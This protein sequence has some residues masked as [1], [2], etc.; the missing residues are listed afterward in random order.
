MR[1]SLLLSAVL[2]SAYILQPAAP[3][4]A[5]ANKQWD[6]AEDKQNVSIVYLVR[7]AEKADTGKDPELTDTGK[8]R[9]EDLSRMLKDAGI[10]HIWTTDFKRTRATVEP[11]SARTRVKLE[12][13]DPSKLGEF[14]TRLKSIPGRHL[15]VGHSNTTP[16]LVQALGGDPGPPMPDSEYDR[17]YIVTLGQNIA[18]IQLRFGASAR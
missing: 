8:E 7:H 10:T 1:A 18:T 11:L 12:V 3:L 6:R 13:Y 17:L 2:A 4:A 14:A 16:G 9:A 5:Q 15:V